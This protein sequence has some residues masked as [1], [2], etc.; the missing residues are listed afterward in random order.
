MQKWGEKIFSNQKFG[1][2]VYTMIVLVIVLE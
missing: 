2:T 1:M